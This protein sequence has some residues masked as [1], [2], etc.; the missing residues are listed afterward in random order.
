MN[1]SIDFQTVTNGIVHSV[2]PLP[3]VVGYFSP[4]WNFIVVLFA[5]LMIV[6]VKH[7][8]S[9]RFGLMLSVFMQPADSEKLMREWN[10]ATELSW[11]AIFA[12]NVA[13]LALMV[14][15]TI[16]VFSGK[17]LLY[18]GPDFYLDICAFIAALYIVQHLA[19]SLYSRL[20]GIETAALYHEMTHVIVM[21]TLNVALLVLDVIIIFYPLKVIITISLL[22]L[23][24]IIGFRI[25]KTFF[26]FQSLSK[27]NLFNNFLYFCAIEIIPVSVAVTMAFRLIVTDCVL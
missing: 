24:I 20:F 26:G 22:I 21:S 13:L 27:M 8:G 19:I 18:G 17:T 25:I 5:I 6:L 10:P 15:K 3:R 12:A 16:L 9:R 14:Q 4:S 23:L 7:F 2:E 1:D 11:G